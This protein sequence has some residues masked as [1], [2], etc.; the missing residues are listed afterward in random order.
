MKAKARLAWGAIGALL[1]ALGTWVVFV[2]RHQ[3]I[4]S[5]GYPLILLG[6]IC[7]ARAASA[8]DDQTP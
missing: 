6:W 8:K 3:G 2:E 7:V 4:E 5:P 1:V